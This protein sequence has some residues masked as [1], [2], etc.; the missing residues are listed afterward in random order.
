MPVLLFFHKQVK[1]KILKSL[2][3]ISLCCLPLI[4]LFFFLNLL[5][6]AGAA[7]LRFAVV[8]WSGG[9]CWLLPEWRYSFFWSSLASWDEQKGCGF[10]CH[11]SEAAPSIPCQLTRTRCCLLRSWTVKSLFWQGLV[12]MAQATSAQGRVT[13]SG[14]FRAVSIT[15]W[16]SPKVEMPQP[17]WSWPWAR[18]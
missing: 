2:A 12:D 17:A 8:Q 16:M 18:Q 9:T 5:H 15:I 11:P 14:L 13:S 4:L 3:S 1:K 10:T 7:G 6:H